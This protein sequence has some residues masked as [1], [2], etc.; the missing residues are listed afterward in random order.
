[1]HAFSGL[2]LRTVGTTPM[3]NRW[4]S[5]VLTGVCCIALCGCTPS[6]V[7]RYKAVADTDPK[8]AYLIARQVQDASSTNEKYMAALYAGMAAVQIQEF[9]KAEECLALAA[10][11]P[12]PTRHW[13]RAQALA[14]QAQLQ[15][16]QTTR[17]WLSG[18][19][20]RDRI[21]AMRSLDESLARSGTLLTESVKAFILDEDYQGAVQALSEREVAEVLRLR[22]NRARSVLDAVSGCQDFEGHILMRLAN[23]MASDEAPAGTHPRMKLWREQYLFVQGSLMEW[24]SH[25]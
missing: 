23:R 2:R 6:W 19:T 7:G 16:A 15:F 12:M 4:L 14:S 24:R 21:E 13:V 10:Q 1:M 5:P 11:D 22:L 3:R 25:R 18:G 20:V 9:D 8:Q 17:H